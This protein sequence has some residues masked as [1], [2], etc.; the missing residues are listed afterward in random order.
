MNF[1]EEAIVNAFV[2]PAR[3]ER[4]LDAL[5]NPKN[6]YKFTDELNHLRSRLL[7]PAFMKPLRGTE[8]LAQNVYRTL[9]K[10]GGPEVCW[11]IG[12]RFDESEVELLRAL[13]N[14]GDGFL[15]SCIPGK[16][17]YLKTE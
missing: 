2:D 9:R 4:F 3:Q 1:H 16:L 6:R 15:L 7:I 5:A 11:V 13:R 10:A 12:G 8:S 14:S 17:A